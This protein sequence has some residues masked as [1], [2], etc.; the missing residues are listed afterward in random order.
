MSGSATTQ[1]IPGSQYIGGAWSVATGPTLAVV[2]PATEATLAELP[3]STDSDVETALQAARAAQREWARTPSP[4]RGAHLRA[5]ADVVAERA[6]A[7]AT[8]LVREV[9]KPMAQAQGEVAFAESLLRYNAE[10]DR[11]LEGDVLPGDSPGEQIHLLR[12]PLGVVAAICR[13]TSRSPCSA[14]R[15]RRR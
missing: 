10:W 1:T 14:A 8:L 13:G 12:E 7:L 9:G 4:T 5:I 3:S 15:S 2:D 11:R 6:D